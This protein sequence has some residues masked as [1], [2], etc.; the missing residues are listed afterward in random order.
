MSAGIRGAEVRGRDVPESAV[1]VAELIVSSARLRELHECSALLRRTRLRAGEI[2]DEA[3][4][5]L[6]EAERQGDPERIV[7]LDAQLG[8]A[9][10]AYYKVFNAYL[11]ICRR[12]NEERQA[13]LRTQTEQGRRT[14]LSGA[15]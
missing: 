8:E 4:A 10:Q 14:G 2:V 5:M 7:A 3:R 1:H 9:R 15:A 12:I 11:T 6:A 13:I